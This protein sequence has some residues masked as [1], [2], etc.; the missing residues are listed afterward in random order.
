MKH[1]WLLEAVQLQDVWLTIGSFDGVH[2]G[3]QA[4]I[5]K[6]TDGAHSEGVPAVVVTFHP[7][8]AAVLRGRHG[9]YYLTTPEERAALLGEAGV[10]VVI[11]HPFNLE[12]SNLSAHDFMQRLQNHL[13]IKHL[14]IGH[15]FALGRQR[16]GDLPSLVRLGEDFGYSVEAIPPVELDGQVVSSSRIRTALEAGDL[17]TANRLSGRPFRLDGKVMHGD[18]RGKRIGIPTA[19]LSFWEQHVLP[20]PGVYAC[21]VKLNGRSYPAVTNVGYRPTFEGQ[22]ANPQV[23]AHLLDFDGDLYQQQLQL[24]FLS[25]LRDEQRFQ[26]VEALVSQIHKDIQKAREIF[27]AIAISG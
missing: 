6:I 5:N 25:R 14:C 11:T 7:H 20:K 10:D 22:P 26:N 19:N 18:G 2:L 9:R 13:G 27:S 21:T 16:E 23:E 12:I 3:H 1:Y 17:E 4:I 24:A 15:D 8:P